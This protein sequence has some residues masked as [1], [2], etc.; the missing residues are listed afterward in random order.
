MTGGKRVEYWMGA[1]IISILTA[2][3][4]LALMRLPTLKGNGI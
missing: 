4:R 2:Y 3:K 1:G